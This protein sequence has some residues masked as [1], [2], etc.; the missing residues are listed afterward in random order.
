MKASAKTTSKGPKVTKISGKDL[1]VMKG[2]LGQTCSKT[3]KG[4]ACSLAK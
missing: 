2:G 1:K 4:Q 3:I